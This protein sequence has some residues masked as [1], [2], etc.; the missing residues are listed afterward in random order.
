MNAVANAQL[1][2]QMLTLLQKYKSG[3]LGVCV[4]NLKIVGVRKHL[5]PVFTCHCYKS[6]VPVQGPVEHSSQGHNVFSCKAL[7]LNCDVQSF[8][9]CWHYDMEMPSALL[10]FCVRNPL[11]TTDIFCLAWTS[12]STKTVMLLVIC[13]DLM[14]I[15][16]FQSKAL[17]MPYFTSDH[18]NGLVQ[19]KLNSS[20]NALEL[21]LFCTDPV[22]SSLYQVIGIG[23]GLFLIESE[24]S[25]ITDQKF[26]RFPYNMISMI[27]YKSTG[28][29]LGMWPAYEGH[30]YGTLLH[31]NDVPHWLGTYLDRS[32]KA[33]N[34]TVVNVECLRT[35]G[36][37]L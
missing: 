25:F 18:I 26:N 35:T 10:A 9:L 16:V 8:T 1:T 17:V 5:V 19:K 23:C 33:D 21:H 30:R 27:L 22:I 24:I 13:D 31:C 12:Y 7:S 34:M 15:T 36:C 29:S 37:L 4:S 14:L 20:A 3:L 32:L 11:V 28:V 6:Y 2:F